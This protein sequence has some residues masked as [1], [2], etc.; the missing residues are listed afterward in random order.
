MKGILRYFKG[1]KWRSLLGPLFKL[2]EATFELL[3]P[4]VVGLIVDRGIAQNDTAYI[5]WM[6]GLLALFGLLGLFF[7]VI[8]QYFAARTATGV[9][10]DIRK[11]LFKKMQSLSYKDI[12]RMGFST[13]L[14]RMTSD[15][16]RLQ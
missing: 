6:C 11:D 15:V 3:V 5:A 8:A 13:M 7:S 10:A 4:I 14:T 2:L 12:D 9:A 16:D 1:Y